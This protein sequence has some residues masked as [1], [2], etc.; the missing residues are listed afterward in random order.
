MIDVQTI[1]VLPRFKNGGE[2][3]KKHACYR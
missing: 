3:T 2:L 1:T